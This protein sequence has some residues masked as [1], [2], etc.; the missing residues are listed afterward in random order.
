MQNTNRAYKCCKNRYVDGWLNHIEHI[1]HVIIPT[2]TVKNVH[3]VTV[4]ST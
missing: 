4:Y 1:E 2:S 3:S